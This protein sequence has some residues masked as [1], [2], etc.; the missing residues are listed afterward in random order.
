[1]TLSRLVAYT[2]LAIL[3]DLSIVPVSNA[4]RRV[5]VLEDGSAPSYAADP[6]A[7]VDFGFGPGVKPPLGRLPATASGSIPVGG[8][9]AN[10]TGVFGAPIP[11]PIIAIHVVLLPDGRV[12]NYGTDETGA[13]GA[14]LLYDVWD[15]TLAPSSS[16]H[17]VLPNAT[18]TDIFC[19]G[20]SVMWL[21]GD[22]LITGG[23]LTINGKRNYSNNDTTI[24]APQTNTLT[25]N[26]QMAFPRWYASLVSLPNGEMAV[27]GGRNKS[28]TG[29]LLS[30]TPEVFNP[31]TGWRTLT[32]AESKAAFGQ[33][34][35]PRS[36]VAPGGN[37]FVLAVDGAM[38]SVGTAGSGSIS[39]YRQPTLPGSHALP[40]VTFS[41]GKLLSVRLNA[42]AIIV[43]VT[44]PVPAITPTAPMSQVRYWASGTVLPDGQVLVTGGSQVENKL[45][46]VAYA[47]EIWNP[48]SGQ[49]TL[50]A[51]ATV[52][53][54]YHSNALLLPDGT[55]LT[56]GGG[57]PGPVRNLNAEIYY[58]PYLYM[59][60]GS[61]QPAPRPSLSGTPPS[62]AVGQSISAAVGPTDQIARMTLVRTGSATHGNNSDQRFI[63]LTGFQQT[64]QQVSAT[65]PSDP[66]ILLPGYYMLFVFNQAGVPSVAN[67]ILI[68]G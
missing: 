50:G 2:L 8:P 7:P 6:S 52:P 39:A 12:L 36:Y 14:E 51:S 32:G 16:P 68:S 22:V 62:T 43:D 57:A 66:T 54:L 48:T 44:G 38:F 3:T 29:K 53:R 4:D 41:P 25:A 9:S 11:W 63:D 55:V 45:T 5:A 58:P 19:S 59:N 49:W 23:D 65:L 56:A 40:T 15:P 47:A 1:M 42:A 35:Y 27:F 24:F 17:L 61:G 10:V 33:W 30:I 20:Q 64:G 18:V 67:I 13:Q 28:L 60:D 37:V 46:G 34:Y 26:P 21:N 31:A